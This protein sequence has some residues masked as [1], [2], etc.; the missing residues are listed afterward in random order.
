MVSFFSFLIKNIQSTLDQGKQIIL[1]KNRR[2]Y[3][4]ILECSV[5]SWT[6]SCTSCNVSLTYHKDKNQ[7]RCHYCGYSQEKVNKCNSCNNDNMLYK[8]FGTQQIEEEL[9]ILFPDAKTK[10]MDYD[11]TRKK[12]AYSSIISDFERGVIDIL[13]GTQMV[14]KGLDFDNVSL[15]GVLNLQILKFQ[16]LEALERAIN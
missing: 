2:G 3:T 10:R 8:G 13:I 15:V 1:F 11:S 4:P 16:I 7:L 6:P 9:K 5:C 14:T 12:Q